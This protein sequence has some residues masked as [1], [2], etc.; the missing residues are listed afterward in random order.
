VHNSSVLNVDEEWIAGF[1]AGL[2]HEQAEYS[3]HLIGGDTSST[4]GPIT[5]AVTALAELPI[6]RIIR[7]GGAQ[8]GDL[9]FVA[10]TIG[11]AALGLSVL[12]G[13]RPPPL[14]R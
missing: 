10:G 2:A 9:I 12:R 11:D 14:R 1:A 5:V 13:C 3:I 6:G 7:R 8:P 4:S